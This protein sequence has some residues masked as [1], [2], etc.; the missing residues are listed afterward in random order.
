MYL[1]FYELKK[2]P[3]QVGTNPDFLWLGKMHKEALALLKY[4][5]LEN[6]GFLLLT[7][8]VGTGKTTLVAA[9][10]NSLG[11]GV[12][13]A[14]VPDP[15]LEVIDFMNYISHAFGLDEKFT[16]KESFL[17]Q[18]G[19]FLNTA[20]AAGKKV[21]LIIDEAQR[22]SC[23]LLEEIRQLSNIEKQETKILNI[24]FVGQNEFNDIL[25]DKK[26]RALHQRIAINYAI[27]PLDF[28]ETGEFVRQ[29]LLLAGAEKE[30]FSP[31][32]IR[33]IYKFSGGFLRRIN[34]LCDHAMLS[35][36]IQERKIITGDMVRECAGDLCLPASHGKSAA[37]P[38]GLADEA[39][40]ESGKDTQ[41][42]RL[43]E[44]GS[45]HTWRTA[46]TVILLVAAVL[47]VTYINYPR[48][49][50]NL[51]Y[52]IRNNGM[53]SFS[54]PRKTNTPNKIFKTESIRN[55]QIPQIPANLEKMSEVMVL[56][57]DSANL[58]VLVEKVKP[59]G[60]IS[61]DQNGNTRLQA[62]PI[63]N[64]TIAI[65]ENETRKKQEN[66]EAAASHSTVQI[67]LAPPLQGIRERE[68]EEVA[69]SIPEFS[70]DS[71]TLKSEPEPKLEVIVKE[72][73]RETPVTVE[74]PTLSPG[75]SSHDTQVR[76]IDSSTD[77]GDEKKEERDNKFEGEENG[78]NGYSELETYL[79]QKVNGE[80]SDEV[81]KQ[82]ES[83]ETEKAL[84]KNSENT[85]PGA[86]I[87][88][89]LKNRSK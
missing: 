88:W 33:N 87:D 34:I 23:Q 22:L 59:A 89:V 85:D 37:S 63:S 66:H 78:A 81:D 47:I 82:A 40:L 14:K 18:F 83:G 21:L 7:G 43:R 75:I 57:V 11:D 55:E 24:L 62:S 70:A 84:N 50:K 28:Y 27:D 80:L 77:K 39:Y 69:R 5:V 68:S 12:I 4:G 60:T 73:R 79:T 44:N 30:I 32:A 72:D 51:I 26:N 1:F 15:G 10:T 71:G 29:I 86:V 16:C 36:F 74:K 31:D 13:V 48:E 56:G 58:S 3:F 54:V 76:G 38:P 25:L 61:K 53:Q 2:K 45:I 67:N 17:I 20:Q 46:V 9:L 64:K 8:D 35:G 42:E 6:K 41:T 49:Y 65:P 52:R 19:E